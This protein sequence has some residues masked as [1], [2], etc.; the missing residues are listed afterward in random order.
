MYVATRSPQQARE[1]CD[2][3]EQIFRERQGYLATIAS[4]NACNEAD[5]Q[6]ALSEAFA[7]FHRAYDPRGKAPPLAWLA[8]TIKR[9]CWR[10]RRDAHLNRQAG[11][12]RPA[13]SGEDLDSV[14]IPIPSRATAPDELIAER[15]DARCRIARLKPDQRTA[16]ALLAAGYS[17][18]EIA[19]L[20]G[21]TYT[22]VNRCIREGR[23]ALRENLSA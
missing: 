13:E 18:K 19:E 20:K 2:L 8:L 16:L 14:L 5:A 9:E 12:A 15:D 1:V 22:K 3:A 17:Y 11:R 21:W 10:K 23:A 6:E 7:A 4:R